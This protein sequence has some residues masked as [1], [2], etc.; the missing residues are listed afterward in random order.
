MLAAVTAFYGAVS[1]RVMQV[2]DLIT[3]GRQIRRDRG[4]EEPDEVTDARQKALAAKVKQDAADLAESKAIPGPLKYER[5]KSSVLAVQCPWCRAGI[6]TRCSV[7]RTNQTL[8]GYHP[9]RIEASEA[10]A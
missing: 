1:G 6:G 3:Y 7:P 8:D 10:A 9:S 5:P 2:A 4:M